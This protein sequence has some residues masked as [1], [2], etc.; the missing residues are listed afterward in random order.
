MQRNDEPVYYGDYLELDKILNAQQLKSAEYGKKAHDETLF[1]IVHQVYELWFK[2]ILHELNSILSIF[3]QEKVE[4][5]EMGTIN[6]RLGRIIEIQRVLQEQFSVIETM[7]PL[8][9]LDFR[10]YLVP[11][12]GF[13]SIQFRS[14]EIKLGLR[15]NQRVQFDQSSFIN[16]LS[17]DDKKYLLA[18]EGSPSLLDFLEK[19][20]ERLPF[21]E[22]GEFKFWKLY[23]E[24]VESMLITDREIVN[25]RT[26][27]TDGEK[28]KQLIELDV[29]EQSFNSILDE[30]LFAELKESN[31]VKLSQKAFLSALF[32]SLYRDEPAL[33]AP[34]KLIQNLIDIDEN[35]TNWR[36][37]HALLA[38]R[39]LG[40]KIGTGGSSGHEY[41]KSTT[42]NNRI[43]LDFFNL[44][45]FLIPRSSL[46]ELPKKVRE[47]L[48]FSF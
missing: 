43:F 7:T 47:K 33:N 29:T 28:Q 8:D 36:H 35:F 13:Q 6:Q 27:L 38:H 42:S 20:L 45:T 12:S 4:E 48:N 15:M 5:R 25:N 37:R 11:A 46:P 17:E 32:I 26:Q 39:M 40:T 1:I 44:S 10:D 30:G 34:Y 16:R 24:A 9:F 14:I 19:W 21:L 23:K 22:F 2:Q 31:V 3:S 41:L 18:V